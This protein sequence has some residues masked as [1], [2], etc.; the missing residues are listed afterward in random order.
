VSGAWNVLPPSSPLH[1]EVDLFTK[2]HAPINPLCQTVRRNHQ[3]RH[4]NLLLPRLSV[5]HRSGAVRIRSP[6]LSRQVLTFSVAPTIEVNRP[7]SQNFLSAPTHCA[8]ATTF[9]HILLCCPRITFT[10]PPFS[11]PRPCRPLFANIS[12]FPIR[13]DR[14]STPCRDSPGSSWFP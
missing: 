11:K 2:P 1:N 4:L 14:V 3:Q 9:I 10:F 13:F 6:R 5:H 7:S 8:S 12:S